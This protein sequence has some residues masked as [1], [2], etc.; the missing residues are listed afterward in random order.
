[1][2]G[3]SVELFIVSSSPVVWDPARNVGGMSNA[4]GAF[5]M[6]VIAT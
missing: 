6:R 1:M 3:G 2:C 4:S 5:V